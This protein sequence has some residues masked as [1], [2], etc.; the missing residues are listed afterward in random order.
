MYYAP[1]TTIEQGLTLR[2]SLTNPKILLLESA[3]F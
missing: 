2:N 1:E 3:G